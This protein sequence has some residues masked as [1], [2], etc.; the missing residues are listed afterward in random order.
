MLFPGFYSYLGS[1]S[2]TT[3]VSEDT[4]HSSSY[5][6]PFRHWWMKHIS[7]IDVG[8]S[9]VQYLLVIILMNSYIHWLA[10]TEHYSAI[11]EAAI[12]TLLL[13]CKKWCSK[14]FTV[15]TWTNFANLKS[16]VLYSILKFCPENKYLNSQ[17][18]K[19]IKLKKSTAYVMTVCTDK[20]QCRGNFKSWIIMASGAIYSKAKPH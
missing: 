7:T 1:L 3:E 16:R 20:W 8:T 17:R 6:F 5:W 19:E 9:T 15:S 4:N 13:H 12:Q 14:T 18:A 11:T 2:I 10:Y